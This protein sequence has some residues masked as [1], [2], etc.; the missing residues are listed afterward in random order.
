VGQ[1]TDMDGTSSTPATSVQDSPTKEVL[2]TRPVNTDAEALPFVMEDDD[3]IMIEG[4]LTNQHSKPTVSEQANVSSKDTMLDDGQTSMSEKA[5]GK[6][7][8]PPQDAVK[9]TQSAIKP[10][11]IDLNV[12]RDDDS[13]SDGL[14]IV[15]P[16]ANFKIGKKEI[17]IEE[18]PKS[19]VK[20]M[21]KLRQL[22]R[23]QDPHAEAKLRDRRGVVVIPK[24]STKQLMEDL[25]RKNREQIRRAQEE[26][27]DKLRA[28][29][30]YIPTD[31][32]REREKEVVEDLVEAERLKDLALQKKER[33]AAM[34]NGEGSMDEDDEEDGDWMEDVEDDI[35]LSG[36][37]DELIDEAAED[38]GESEL[39][40]DV[41][42]EIDKGETSGDTAN[43][44][45]I[46]RDVSADEDEGE[47]SAVRLTPAQFTRRQRLRAVVDDEDD[48]SITQVPSSMAS[49]K[50]A[51]PFANASSE[52]LPIG[53]TQM[54]NGS[55]E[56]DTILSTPQKQTQSAPLAGLGTQGIPLGL[57]QMFESSA[58]ENPSEIST[59]IMAQ[60]R[61]NSLRDHD[62]KD[63]SVSQIPLNFA[64]AKGDS[65]ADSPRK[66]GQTQA[67]ADYAQSDVLMAS[68]FPHT[69]MDIPD[70]TPDQ[71]FSRSLARTPPR[72]MP[73]TDM[74][75]IDFVSDTQ[76][77]A[78][79]ET[80]VTLLLSPQNNSPK[81]RGRL[82][83]RSDTIASDQNENQGESDS[84][85]SHGSESSD[86]EAAS[87]TNPK[88]DA[89]DIMKKKAKEATRVAMN[90]AEK[91]RAKEMFEEAAEESEDEYAGF[92]GNSDEEDDDEHSSEFEDMIDDKDDDNVNEREIAELY[93]YVHFEY[94]WVFT[95]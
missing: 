61:M 91:A 50:K 87:E 92:G 32:E 26:E 88:L 64:G 53:L 56:S 67:N 23:M 55:L 38:D 5:L 77:V 39:D 52:P 6:M 17:K 29:G 83:K 89:F 20:V 41:D 18:E 24:V 84:L 57:T 35:E 66:S 86:D 59:A 14:E 74:D 22:A 72:F 51:V 49:F 40:S 76:K 8:A 65:V 69:Q 34:K 62:S 11:K 48:E 63:V 85:A 78:S 90:D 3:N 46:E 21:Q 37:E 58:E 13:D 4:N 45:N 2:T 12:V 94:P 95:N 73:P 71:G 19:S 81:K 54:F 75:M 10:P 42:E 27:K 15:R 93:K 33:K 60:Q 30:I 44:F 16:N 43:V 70:P 9:P 47:D 25:S 28:Q 80:E 36:S 79:A 31:A 7:R 68:Q 82:V 1:D